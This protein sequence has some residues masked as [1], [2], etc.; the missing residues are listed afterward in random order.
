MKK[1]TRRQFLKRSAVGAAGAA[2]VP[3]LRFL[4]G[5][6]VAYAAGPADAI[7]VVVQLDGGNDG[8]NT[9]YPITDNVDGQLALY[10]EYRPTIGLPNTNAGV[11]NFNGAGFDSVFADAT[12]V[13][14][15]GA[16]VDG[17]QYALHPAMTGLHALH[18]AGKLATV[19]SVHYPFPDHSH[20]RSDEI[21]NTGDPLGTGGLGWFGK[22]L[23]YAGFGPTDVP[24]VNQDDSIKPLFTPTNT[25]I[26]AYRRL[27]D[28][29]FPASDESTLKRDKFL[30]LY[31]EAAASD[32]GFYPELKKIGDTG[33]ATINKMELYYKPG[34]GNSGKVEALLINPD[35]ESYD[36]DNPLVYDSPL[37]D[38]NNGN[39]RFIRDMRHVAATIRADVGARFFHVRLGG[40]DSHSNQEDGFYH[41]FLLRELSDGISGLYNELNQSVTLPVGY[42]GYLDGNLASK[43]V[44]VTFS[45]FARTMRQNAY[46]PD[47]AGTDHAASGVQ[48]VVGGSVIGGQ[49]GNH[50]VLADPRVDNQDDLK[51]THDFRDLYGTILSRWLNVPTVDLVGAGKI[52]AQTPSGD[53]NEPAYLGFT[54]IPF[55]A[56]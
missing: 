6:N 39:T 36:Y 12:Q 41:S 19:H 52:F 1:L 28:L 20:F 3:H 23:D 47:A 40:F 37:N 7:V 30:D 33:V 24:C 34:A 9:V 17:S 16:N 45:E 56:P 21:W 15:I 43:V 31:V 50:A 54:A 4:P 11:Q 2:M 13:L 55:L 48:F 42:T 10:Q 5:T 26:F 14:S 53:P 32:P 49:Y 46:G 29:Q 38:P 27:S 44:I 25:S 35:D 18:T 8:L 51:F 22:Y